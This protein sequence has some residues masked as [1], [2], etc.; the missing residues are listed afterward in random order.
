MNTNP[1]AIRILCYGD[2]NTHG[3]IPKTFNRYKINERWTGILQNN[4]GE[5]LDFIVLMLSTND[6]KYRF[7]RQPKEIGDGV[8]SIIDEIKNSVTE[9]EELLPKIIL[10]CPS[11]INENIEENKGK[12]KFEDGEAK[13]LEFPKIYEDISKQNN[14]SYINLQNYI[15]PSKI[16]R[17]TYHC[18]TSRKRNFEFRLIIFQR[19]CFVVKKLLAMTYI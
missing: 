7:N 13:S 16:A 12:D 5:N 19:D 9:Q 4:L 15:K 1:N 14:L 8:Q 11:T 6:L 17:T 3:T 18:K 2:S 10:V